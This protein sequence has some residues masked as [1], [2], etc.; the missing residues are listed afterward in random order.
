MAFSFA[1]VVLLVA[2]AANPSERALTFNNGAVV[3]S[4]SFLCPRGASPFAGIVLLH[5]SG[6]QTREWL[7]P[8]ARGLVEGGAAALVFDKRGT[9]KSTGAWISASLEDLAEDATQAVRTLASQAE[10]NGKPVGVFAISQSG[11][12][13]PLVAMRQPAVRFLTVVTGGGATPRDV[14]WFGYEQALRERGVSGNDLAKAHQVLRGYFEYLA[15][16]KGFTELSRALDEGKGSPWGEA[17]G[18][19]RVLPSPEA[20][21][22][23]AWVATFD[24]QPSIERLH[25]PVLLLFGGRDKQ[26]PTELSLERWKAGLARSEAQATVRVFAEASHGLTLGEHHR[27]GSHPPRYAVGYFETLTAWLREVANQKQAHPSD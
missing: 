27:D 23:W 4:G 16:G 22:N 17:L 12:Y 21:G 15:T 26:L 13:A 9:G 19:G 25:I 5:G 8:I 14:E 2:A 3:L 18:L 1:W 7:L 10:I 20:R 11:W 24:P 6:P